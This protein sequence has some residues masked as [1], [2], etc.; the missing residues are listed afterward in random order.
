MAKQSKGFRQPE[1]PNAG[2]RSDP[3]ASGRQ[4]KAV[5]RQ[6]SAGLEQRHEEAN[7]DLIRYPET[8]ASVIEEPF[9]SPEWIFHVVRA[10]FLSELSATPR[11]SA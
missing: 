9:D 8:V 1:A 10:G 7:F 4:R 3:K 2:R 6:E 5:R 11:R